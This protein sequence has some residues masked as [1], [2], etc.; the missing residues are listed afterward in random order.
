MRQPAWCWGRI[1][2]NSQTRDG[3]Y[4]QGG[5]SFTYEKWAEAGSTF[6]FQM[7]DSGRAWRRLE[8]IDLLRKPVVGHTYG[9]CFALDLHTHIPGGLSGRS[10]AGDYVGAETTCSV[11]DHALH[12]IIHLSFKQQQYSRY[13]CIITYNISH[14]EGTKQKQHLFM[15]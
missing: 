12:N 10:L 11:W 14:N 2:Y 3:I 13:S 8:S 4:L 6:T 9:L 5:L 1:K 15:Q 7:S